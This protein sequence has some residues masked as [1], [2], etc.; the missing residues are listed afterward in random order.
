MKKHVLLILQLPLF[1]LISTL[2]SC[3]HRPLE[4]PIY[5]DKGRF[6]RVY[7][8]EH[9]R[10]VSFGFYD[11]SKQPSNYQSRA[12]TRSVCRPAKRRGGDRALLER[13][14]QR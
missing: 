12:L 14:W 8:N 7:F 1:L 5:F 2:T 13:L 9:I 3:E 11:E 4:D 10:N 6:L